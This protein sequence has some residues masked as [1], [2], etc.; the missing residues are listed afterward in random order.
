[1]GTL[2]ITLKFYQSWRQSVIEAPEPVPLFDVPNVL[3]HRRQGEGRLSKEGLRV[4][5]CDGLVADL[6]EDL[7]ILDRVGQGGQACPEYQPC[8]LGFPERVGRVTRRR[9]DGAVVTHAASEVDAKLDFKDS[10]NRFKFNLLLQTSLKNR[11]HPKSQQ[12][13]SKYTSK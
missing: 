4:L 5:G 3:E 13:L 12:Q 11:Y 7:G 8:P 6:D 10:P 2:K 1:M 9:N